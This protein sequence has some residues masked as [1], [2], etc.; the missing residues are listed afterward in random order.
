MTLHINAVILIIVVILLIIGA[1]TLIA[2]RLAGLRKE[3]LR[4]LERSGR[5]S[6][7][8]DVEHNSVDFRR[9]VLTNF[10]Y[11]NEVWIIKGDE[12]EIDVKLKAFKNGVMVVPCPAR[13]QVDKLCQ[14]HGYRLVEMQVKH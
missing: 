8:P 7:L 11:G 13:F 9:V 10:G 2:L 14:T 6:R 12:S 3:R 4:L 1:V 5:V